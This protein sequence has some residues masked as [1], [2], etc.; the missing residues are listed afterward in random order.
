MRERKGGREGGR[1]G[2]GEGGRKHCTHA[3][4]EAVVSVETENQLFSNSFHSQGLPF[5][6]LLPRKL[7][8]T[9]NPIDRSY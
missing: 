1:E 3:Q 9:N 2:G 5:G 7:P 4:M 6:K 8:P